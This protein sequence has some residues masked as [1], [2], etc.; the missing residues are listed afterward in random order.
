MNGSGIEA[1]AHSGTGFFREDCCRGVRLTRFPPKIREAV[2]RHEVLVG[3][4]HDMV[5]MAKGPPA[6]ESPREG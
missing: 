6:A 5:V 1:D 2:K 4:N 3:M